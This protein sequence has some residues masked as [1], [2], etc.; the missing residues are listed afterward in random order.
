[1]DERMPDDF[2]AKTTVRAGEPLVR[3]LLED[4]YPRP[5]YPDVTTMAD[6]YRRAAAEAIK[7]RRN[8]GRPADI[9]AQLRQAAREVGS[10]VLVLSEDGDALLQ[11][12]DGGALKLM[13]QTDASMGFETTE[14]LFEQ[15]EDADDETIRR[16]LARTWAASG[17]DLASVF[18]TALAEDL[19][20]A[21]ELEAAVAAATD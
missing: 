4:A 18:E 7:E 6:A 10:V 9:F 8:G 11:P 21:A 15:L 3:G 2:P 14:M 17:V 20:D 12:G 19:I 16:G 1:M 13:T 5:E